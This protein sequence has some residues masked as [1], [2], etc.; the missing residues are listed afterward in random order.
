MYLFALL[1]V[2]SLESNFHTVRDLVCFVQS[3]IF[4]SW[5]VPGTKLVPNK[6][7]LNERWALSGVLFNLRGDEQNCWGKS[8][9]CFSESRRAFVL[10]CVLPGRSSVPGFVSP[11]VSLAW[12]VS[13]S[14][15]SRANHTHSECFYHNHRCS[16]SSMMA[17]VSCQGNLLPECLWSFNGR[18]CLAII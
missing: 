8:L 11:W 3:L 16:L 15:E 13:P 6:Y 12:F 4:S 1:S 10:T 2:L 7:L 17:S 18:E 5:R 14:E 9:F